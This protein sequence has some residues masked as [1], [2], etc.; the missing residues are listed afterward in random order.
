[1][2]HLASQSRRSTT[3]LFG[4]EAGLGTGGNHNSSEASGRGRR[5]KGR[6]GGENKATGFSDQ[7]TMISGP[8]RLENVPEEELDTIHIFREERP[9]R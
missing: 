9:G 5:S 2:C 7:G 8:P 3:P 4:G 6:K 1:M